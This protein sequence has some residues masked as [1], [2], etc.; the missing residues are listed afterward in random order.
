MMTK[1]K[2][3]AFCPFTFHCESSSRVL[4]FLFIDFQVGN[5]NESSLVF[6]SIIRGIFLAQFSRL[7]SIGDEMSIISVLYVVTKLRAAEM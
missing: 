2:G 5:F 7:M 3:F 4:V 1:W 6:K